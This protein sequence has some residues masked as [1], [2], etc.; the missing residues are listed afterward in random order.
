MV[1][2]RIR[3]KG[4]P[5]KTGVS[6]YRSIFIFVSWDG[7]N[8]NATCQC[9]WVRLQSFVRTI[10]RGHPETAPSGD[11]GALGERRN[12]ASEAGG[13]SCKCSN[14]CALVPCRVSARPPRQIIIL[15]VNVQESVLDFEPGSSRC[16]GACTQPHL[17]FLW[18]SS[19]L[20]GLYR[21]ICTGK[22]PHV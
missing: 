4:C 15:D 5:A 13:V 7:R 22:A 9:K 16:Q 8:A 12:E 20:D 1:F 21:C 11:Q 2:T 18:T 10:G 6:S 14:K 17:A 19:S 3:A